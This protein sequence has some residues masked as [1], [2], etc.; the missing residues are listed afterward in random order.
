MGIIIKQSIRSTIIT[1]LGIAIG[2]VNVLWLYPKYFTP[3]QIG[4]LRLLQDIPFLLSL[5]VRLGASNI[6]DRY[7]SYYR[8]DEKKHNGFLFII[9]FLFHNLYPACI[10]LVVDLTVERDDVEIGAVR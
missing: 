1:Y 10:R 4:I 7:F 8:D 5:F 6:I 9:L 2:T 3:E